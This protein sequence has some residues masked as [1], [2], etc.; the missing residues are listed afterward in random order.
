MKIRLTFDVTPKQME[1]IANYYGSP[2]TARNET[3]YFIASAVEKA[4]RDVG[5]GKYP[6][7]SVEAE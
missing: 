1:A 5:K 2:G 3:T 7:S 4:L 6:K